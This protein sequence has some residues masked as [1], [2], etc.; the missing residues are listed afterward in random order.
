MIGA[1]FHIAATAL[2][3]PPVGE[4]F[5]TSSSV[6]RRIREG[7]E[8]EEC[9]K[10]GELRVRK[11]RPPDAALSHRIAHRE[12]VIPHHPGNGFGG[13]VQVEFRKVGPATPTSSV[14]AVA[15]RATLG[16]E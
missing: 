5:S 2:C 6:A 1:W 16:G 8:V 12:G 10:I 4:Y 11:L 3:A 14:S 9:H 7:Q 15:T 13:S